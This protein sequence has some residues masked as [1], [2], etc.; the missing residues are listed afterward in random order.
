MTTP[1]VLERLAL[2]GG[3]EVRRRVACNPNASIPVLNKLVRGYPNEILAN[4]FRDLLALRD[5]T[6]TAYERNEHGFYSHYPRFPKNDGDGESMKLLVYEALLFSGRRGELEREGLSPIWRKLMALDVL[7]DYHPRRKPNYGKRETRFLELLT[8]D[9]DAEVR[10]A[11]IESLS[12]PAS[13]FLVMTENGT[14][15]DRLFLAKKEDGLVYLAHRKIAECGE[16]DARR[17]LAANPKASESVLKHL[18]KT[19]EPELRL[20]LAGNP[21]SKK[22]WLDKFFLEGSYE[23]RLAAAQNRS[24]SKK[25]IRQSVGH[26]DP[27]FRM[28]AAVNKGLGGAKKLALLEDSNA[29]VRKV[30]WKFENLDLKV[31]EVW[32]EKTSKKG[33]C[34]VAETAGVSHE[35]L[36]LLARDADDDV[37]RHLAG[38]LSRTEFQHDVPINRELLEILAGDPLEEIRILSACDL[39]LPNRGPLFGGDSSL[40]VREVAAKMV[41]GEG[42]GEFLE[43]PSVA[44]RREAAA[45]A[46]AACSQYASDRM[47]LPDDLKAHLCGFAEDEDLEVRQTLAEADSTPAEA[48]GIL[49]DDKDSDIFATL[50][51]RQKFPRDYTIAHSR[52]DSENTK[53]NAGIVRAAGRSSNPFLRAMAA[54]NSLL[55]KSERAKLRRDEH[56]LVRIQWAIG[57]H[58]PGRASK[59]VSPKIRYASI[60]SDLNQ[61]DDPRIAGAVDLMIRSESAGSEGFRTKLFGPEMREKMLVSAKRI[62]LEKFNSSFTHWKLL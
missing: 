53:L 46:L 4:P 37:R 49:A 20:A 44:V 54:R 52:K 61:M 5:P 62:A 42:P 50:C 21:A 33:R 23:E 51:M 17:A 28:A 18:F 40:C 38:R 58:R 8:M 41:R 32:I 57:R 24:L 15:E 39:R 19:N 35:G 34:L 9:P 59:T 45:S 3:H 2:N 56:P 7:G 6:Q 29:K 47:P 27:K 30:A 48:L 11:L 1:Q 10:N 55:A 60:L 25:W 12:T 36:R 26:G 31:A 16:P 43:D 13:V 14:A 22:A